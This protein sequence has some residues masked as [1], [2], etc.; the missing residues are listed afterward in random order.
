[1]NTHPKAL[2]AAAAAE[3][4]AQERVK[5][6]EAVAK[7]TGAGIRFLEI[8]PRHTKKESRIVPMTLAYFKDRHNIFAV[9]NALCHPDDQFDKVRG[10]ALAGYRLTEGRGVVLRKPSNLTMSDADW[11]DYKFREF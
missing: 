7:M 10:R 6:K 11:L 4:R 1:M 9:A 2:E 3:K 5:M 8:H